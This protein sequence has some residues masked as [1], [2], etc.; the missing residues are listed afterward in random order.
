MRPEFSE[1]KVIDTLTYL[2]GLFDIEKT[3]MDKKLGGDI[4]MAERQR[5]AY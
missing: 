4:K 5:L 3:Q 2:E 1:L